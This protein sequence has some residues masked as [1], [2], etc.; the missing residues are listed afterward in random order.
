LDSAFGDGVALT[1]FGHDQ[2]GRLVTATAAKAGTAPLMQ[3]FTESY[4][5]SDSSWP[6]GASMEN[7]ESVID[8]TG[9]TGYAYMADRVTQQVGAS[10][11]AWQY[12]GAGRLA[13][14]SPPTAS[15]ELEGYSYDVQDQ[16]TQARVSGGATEYLEYDP[17]GLPLFRKVGTKGTWYIGTNATVTAD[18]PSTCTGTLSCLPIA[19]TERVGV[20]VQLGGTRVATIQAPRQN[21]AAAPYAEILYYHR[22]QQGSVVGT[23]RRA[24][25]VD[26]VAGARYRYTPWGQLDKVDGVTAASDSELGYTGGLRLGY[27]PGVVASLTAPQARGLLLLGARVYHAELKRWLQPDT[28]DGR[29]YSYTGGDPVNFRDPRGRFPSNG[30]DIWVNGMNFGSDDLSARMYYEWQTGIGG[31]GWHFAVGM[32]CLEARIDLATKLLARYSAFAAL[33]VQTQTGLTD[34][35]NAFGA[36]ANSAAAAYLRALRYKGGVLVASLNGDPPDIGSEPVLMGEQVV[37]TMPSPPRV[38]V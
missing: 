27:Q 22:D 15:T 35:L 7:L 9:T 38:H 13:M 28:V 12:D 8:A 29:R 6:T 10:A 23:S 18:V 1:P 33:P 2:G 19:G 21:E 11:F 34:I 24:A 16:L 4:S 36:D 32:A 30:S 5:H 20:H 37:N 14:K 3:S 25:G 31:S 17:S 26:G